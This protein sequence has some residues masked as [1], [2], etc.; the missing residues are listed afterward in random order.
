[1]VRRI[2]GFDR[3]RFE[4]LRR[5]ADDV[6]R[7]LR[8]LL[9][10]GVELRQAGV[11]IADHVDAR[12]LRLHEASHARHD[13]V[14]VRALERRQP[15][16]RQQPVDERLQAVG[17]ADDDLRVFDQLRPV[18]L[19]LEELRGAADA[20]ERIPDLV[21]EI[22]DQLAVRLLLLVQP[23][24]ARDLQLLVDVPELEQQRGLARLDRRHRAGQ[25]ELRL[26]GDRE[27]EL[28]LGVGR[29][30]ADRLVDRRGEA[31]GVA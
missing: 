27:L 16:R 31:R 2:R 7:R 4:R 9:R 11:E 20:A 12:K 10:I 17:L 30:A 22:A 26:A 19:A 24:L 15:V 6:E 18:E 23:L 28:L 25:M 3:R 1:M 14:D 29:A 21:R 13:L 8:E 5:V